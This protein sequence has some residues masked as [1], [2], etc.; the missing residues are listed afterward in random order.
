MPKVVSEFEEITA[1]EVEDRKQKLKTKLQVRKSA[2][3]AKRQLF[4]KLGEFICFFCFIRHNRRVMKI[5]ADLTDEGIL[6]EVGERLANA[7][8][9]RNLTQ[10]DLAEQAGVGKRT[11]E[12]LE[13]GQV[14]TQLSG[15]LRVCRVL[16]ILERFDTLIPEAML[17]PIEQLKLQ[18]KKRQRA[19]R[20]KSTKPGPQKWTWGDSS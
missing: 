20:Q 8:L 10:A 14:A 2:I 6:K 19:S 17:S 11:V 13:S 16:G 4:A 15:F 12:R 9:Q 5:T 3:V 1:G 7:R 18:G